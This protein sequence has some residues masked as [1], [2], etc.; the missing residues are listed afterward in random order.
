MLT[1]TGAPSTVVYTLL[2]RQVEGG[3]NTLQVDDAPE[4]HAT[5]ELTGVEH[6]Y[7]SLEKDG[8]PD[9]IF[10]S[11]DGTPL[12]AHRAQLCVVSNNNFDLLLTPSIIDLPSTIELTEDVHTLS[13]ILHVIYGAS[14]D[15]YTPTLGALSD[16]INAFDKYGLAP[17]SRVSP[18]TP[19]F[20]EVT[21]SI[22]RHP[23]ETYTIAAEHDLF[24][25]AQKASEHLLTF[26]LSTISDD[27]VLRLGSIYL[28][29][30]FTLQLARTYVLQNL[31][32]RPPDK[33]DANTQCGRQES[34]SMKLAWIAAASPLVLA[35]H[36]DVST[37]TIQNKFECV[38]TSLHCAECRHCVERRVDEVLWKWSITP[39]T[40]CRDTR[41]LYVALSPLDRT[42]GTMISHL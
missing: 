28:H 32:I 10:I 4:H 9:I 42:R 3:E 2:L 24:D 13:V 14:F 18:G 41:E 23:L 40:I 31:I 7:T 34:E 8:P 19:V 12:Y 16:A 26:P 27:V 5:T 6:T 17:C 35:A 22:S 1:L 33:H 30:L 37:E 36:P 29:R 39:R 20:E 15:P 25:I 21:K 38:K 11:S